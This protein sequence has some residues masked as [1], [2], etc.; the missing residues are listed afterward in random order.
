MDVIPEDK[1]PPEDQSIKQIAALL[2]ELD[3]NNPE[4]KDFNRR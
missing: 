4:I 1:Q 3:T 2:A